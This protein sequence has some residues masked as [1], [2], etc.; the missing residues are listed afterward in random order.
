MQSLLQVAIDVVFTEKLINVPWG[1]MW[2]MMLI[3]ILAV[4]V[5]FYLS[6]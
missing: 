2:L 3:V 6:Q 1:S 4:G 5:D